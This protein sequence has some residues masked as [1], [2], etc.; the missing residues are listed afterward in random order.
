[1]EVTGGNW[2]ELIGG[3]A[4]RSGRKPRIKKTLNVLPV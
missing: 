4:Q 3:V 1:M 2:Y